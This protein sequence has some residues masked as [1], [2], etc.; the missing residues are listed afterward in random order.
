MDADNGLKEKPVCKFLCYWIELANRQGGSKARPISGS[1]SFGT[2]DST[3]FTLPVSR[4]FLEQRAVNLTH[5]LL[6]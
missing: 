4:A 6:S 2:H 5:S 1:S 3:K